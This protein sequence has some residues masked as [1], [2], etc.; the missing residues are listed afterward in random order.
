MICFHMNTIYNAALLEWGL[1][2]LIRMIH[3]SK[4][5]EVIICWYRHRYVYSSDL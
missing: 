5:P 4:M 3:I 1:P 2:Q